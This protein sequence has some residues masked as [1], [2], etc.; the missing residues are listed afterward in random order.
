MGK[1][2]GHGGRG[3]GRSSERAGRRGRDRGDAADADEPSITY[4]GPPLSMWDFEQCDPK[5]CSGRKLVRAGLMRS[6]RPSATSRGIVLTPMADTAVSFADAAVALE[7]GVAVVDCSWARVDDVPF[8]TLR[9]GPP[10]LLPFLVAANPVNYG[11]PL[12][13]TC[14]EAVAAALYVMRFREEARQVME[15][16]GWG[17]A[18]F[19]V[20]GELLERYAL[21]EDSAQVVAVQNEY[22]AECEE[23]VRQKRH[24]DYDHAFQI[25]DESESEGE[26]EDVGETDDVNGEDAS[27]GEG[28]GQLGV[29]AT[30]Q[31][32]TGDSILGD[33]KTNESTLSLSAETKAKVAEG[34]EESSK[35]PREEKD[36]LAKPCVGTTEK[37]WKASAE[38]KT[39]TNDHLSP[40]DIAALA[41]R[42]STLTLNGR[43]A[44]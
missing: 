32:A 26:E 6:L 10:R 29:G 27:I 33:K 18:F 37:V 24:D 9:G 12:R 4:T 43:D 5:R 44:S 35:L 16:F 36:E 1:R 38:S 20:N 14:A 40:S 11:R 21:C 13:L 22:I 2:R 30:C 28:A 34:E 19:E 17:H 42:A 7:R 15:G 8:A 3:R 31:A 25:D 39:V 41:T 23:E